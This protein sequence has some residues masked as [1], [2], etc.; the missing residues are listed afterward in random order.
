MMIWFN[1]HIIKYSAVND[2]FLP[3]EAIKLIS[4][5]LCFSLEGSLSL[6]NIKDRKVAGQYYDQSF[7]RVSPERFI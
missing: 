4:T 3:F 1:T 2:Y 6:T 5:L 7:L